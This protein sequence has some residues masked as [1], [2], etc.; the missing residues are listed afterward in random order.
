MRVYVPFGAGW[1]LYL[2]L[3]LDEHPASLYFVAN[4]LFRS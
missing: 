1:C 2:L 3:R 4:N